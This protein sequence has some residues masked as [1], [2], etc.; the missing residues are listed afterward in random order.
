MTIIAY[1]TLAE[2]LKPL[3]SQSLGNVYFSFL[4]KIFFD[5]LEHVTRCATKNKLK[6][7]KQHEK[8]FVKKSLP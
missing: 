4:N 8:Q 3:F 2:Q 7:N 6:A 5:V 1:R